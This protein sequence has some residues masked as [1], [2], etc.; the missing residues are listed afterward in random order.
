MKVGTETEQNDA[1]HAVRGRVC[2]VCLDSLD[3]G[4]CGLDRP[5]SCV[6]QHSLDAVVRAVRLPP[7]GQMN[8][9]VASLESG[10]CGLC[11]DGPDA[12]ECARRARAD[13]AL[14]LYLPLIVGV[15]RP[16][17]P[18]PAPAGSRPKLADPAV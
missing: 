5:T 9:I 7:G 16:S 12:S 11:P 17:P 18:T 14:W 4:T 2:G 13:C 15:L 10:V 6:L 3:D 1:W 8:E